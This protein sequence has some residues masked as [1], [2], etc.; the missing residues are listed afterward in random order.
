MKRVNGL[1]ETGMGLGGSGNTAEKGYLKVFRAILSLAGIVFIG[2]S[3]YF[4]IKTFDLVDGLAL[5]EIGDLLES[6]VKAVFFSLSVLLTYGLDV[7]LENIVYFICDIL[8]EYSAV[9]SYSEGNEP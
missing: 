2:I 5:T 9:K 4:W 3:V 8:G 1:A 6:F 7:F